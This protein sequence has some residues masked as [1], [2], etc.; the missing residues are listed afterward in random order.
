[1]PYDVPQT[2][3]SLRSDTN[4]FIHDTETDSQTQNRLA[5]VKGWKDG[6]GVWNQQMEAII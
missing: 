5:A 3:W 6:V 1:M 2:I 4:E